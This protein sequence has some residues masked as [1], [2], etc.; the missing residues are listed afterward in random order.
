MR[1]IWIEE[2][3]GQKVDNFPTRE[4]L[5]E[6]HKKEVNETRDFFIKVFE[7]WRKQGC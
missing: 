6:D 2:Y 1:V 3:D 5:E 7:Q 4:E